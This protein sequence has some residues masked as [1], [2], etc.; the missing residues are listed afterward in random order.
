MAFLKNMSK[1]WETDKKEFCR[2]LLIIFL[3]IEVISLSFSIA[4]SSIAFVFS[5]IL[6][7]TILII[8]KKWERTPIDYFFI[9]FIIA[10]IIS[11]IFSI[12]QPQ[13]FVNMKRLF[14]FTVFYMTFYAFRNKE[15]IKKF[16]TVFLV[17][18]AFL[19]LMEIVEKFL[20]H[21]DRIGIFQHY[22]TTGGIKMI[23]CLYALPNL[24]NKNL[25]KK[26]KGILLGLF[27][28]IFTSLILTMTRSSWLGFLIGGVVLGVIYNKKILLYIIGFLILFSLFAPSE[29]KDRALSSF[30]PNHPSNR[31]RIHMVETG[32]RIFKDYPVV[33]IGDID[34]KKLYLQYTVPFDK[35]EGGHL[36][37]NFIQIL[38]CFGAF[39][40]IIFA[41]LFI[42]LLIFLIKNFILVR[43][44][45]DLKILAIIPIMV[46]FA[47]HLNGLFEWNFGDQEIAILLWFTMGISVISRNLYLKNNK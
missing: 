7:V 37:D 46:F 40:F 47:F 31:T 15:E 5:V 23:V 9:L 4:V 13:S 22:M 35:D 16:I 3:S 34:V 39:G 17:F 25:S 36:H 11:T 26:E 38:V 14:I 43:N 2:R 18:I 41:L 30:D 45:E 27:V 1:I 42:S 28:I 33:G 20:F 44:D 19:S 10:E 6:W 12:N 21:I 29:I 32:F 8:E 24:F